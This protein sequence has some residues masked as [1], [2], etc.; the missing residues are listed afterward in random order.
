MLKDIRTVSLYFIINLINSVK[1]IWNFK[2]N[3]KLFIN[4]NYVMNLFFKFINITNMHIFYNLSFININ[5]Y[6][7]YV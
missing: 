2:L 4:I 7:I 6:Y 5:I 1:N 3:C